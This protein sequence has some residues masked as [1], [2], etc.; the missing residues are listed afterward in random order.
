MSAEATRWAWEQDVS[1]AAKLVLLDMAGGANRF[2]WCEA[3]A[4][5]LSESLKITRSTAHRHLASLEKAGLIKHYPEMKK[6]GGL[7]VYKLHL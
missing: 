4:K 1:S 2:G 7:N 3:T 6:A 5:T